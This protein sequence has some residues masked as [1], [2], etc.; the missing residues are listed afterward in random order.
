MSK[1]LNR[2]FVGGKSRSSVFFIY[3]SL[4]SFYFIIVYF[5]LVINIIFKIAF[6]IL[7]FLIE[8]LL[9][10]KKRFEYKDDVSF[11]HM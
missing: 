5:I 3:A 7:K 8:I 2:Y 6:E 10:N 4:T 9:I 1:S 11:W